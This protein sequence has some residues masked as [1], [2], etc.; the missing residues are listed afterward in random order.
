MAATALAVVAQGQ[1]GTSISLWAKLYLLYMNN[2]FS[3]L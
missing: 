3:F 1:G 2:S